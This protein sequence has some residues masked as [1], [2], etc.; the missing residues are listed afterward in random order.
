MYTDR[1]VR[2]RLCAA[3]LALVFAATSLLG[4]VCQ[5]DCDQP[6]KSATCHESSTTSAGE[7]RARSVHHLCDHDHTGCSAGLV[8][9]TAGARESVGTSLVSVV[10][11]TFGH[12]IVRE[13]RTP[14]GDMHGPPGLT[15]RSVSSRTTV[16][17][18]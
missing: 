9:S 17:R 6:T 14:I 7:A 10:I 18:I 4:A 2:H 3:V 13:G 1:V 5:M 8:T 12:A 16:L 11:S 15:S